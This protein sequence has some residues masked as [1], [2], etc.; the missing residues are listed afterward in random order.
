MKDPKISS[1]NIKGALNGARQD[2]PQ[3]QQFVN[4][5]SIV[6]KMPKLH[7]VQ[8]IF[9]FVPMLQEIDATD[10]KC[11]RATR[12]KIYQLRQELFSPL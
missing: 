8:I 12:G 4:S 3:A 11:S 10:Q 2:I 1:N 9:N 5:T 7:L 6:R